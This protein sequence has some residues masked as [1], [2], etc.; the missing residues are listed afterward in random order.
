VTVL[1]FG[2]KVL[3]PDHPTL[4]AVEGAMRALPARYRGC[5]AEIAMRGCDADYED[6]VA[7]RIRASESDKEAACAEWLGKQVTRRGFAIVAEL[8]STPVQSATSMSSPRTTATPTRE[9]W[10]MSL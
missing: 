7:V 6:W 3:D 8:S 2:T 5:D 4:A 1:A 10:R 9:G